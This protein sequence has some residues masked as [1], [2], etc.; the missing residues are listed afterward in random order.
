MAHCKKKY[1]SFGERLPKA[2]LKIYEKQLESLLTWG[3]FTCFF[4]HYFA[5]RR[6]PQLGFFEMGLVPPLGFF[7]MGLVPLTLLHLIA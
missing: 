2:G 3:E 5:G 4:R 7:E 1:P 6:S